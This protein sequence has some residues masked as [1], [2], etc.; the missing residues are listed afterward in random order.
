M[1]RKQGLGER[2]F[3]VGTDGAAQRSGT[4]VGVVALLD[5]E[6]LGLWSKFHIHLLV[7]KTIADL[8]EFHID[9]VV[10]VVLEERTEYHRIIEA[11][12]ELG[13]E[14]LLDFTHQRRANFFVI[15]DLFT[16]AEAEGG[17]ALDEV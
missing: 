13:P 10:E 5:E 7:S 14:E 6:V 4:K 3:D 11:I 12:D 9:D 1:A 16:F 15:L 2:V 8:G 17:A